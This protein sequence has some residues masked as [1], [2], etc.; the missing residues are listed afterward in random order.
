LSLTFLNKV[1]RAVGSPLLNFLGLYIL[2]KFL[3]RFAPFSIPLGQYKGVVS[4]L[5]GSSFCG[6]GSGIQRIFPGNTVE[7]TLFSREEKHVGFVSRES[8]TF[9]DK[10]LEGLSKS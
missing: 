3:L 9:V 2:K 7:Q 6:S 1:G 4:L 10:D 8:P 5:A